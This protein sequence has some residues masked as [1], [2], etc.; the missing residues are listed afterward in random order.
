MASTL[1][2]PA[3]TP[4][5][6]VTGQTCSGLRE[7]AEGCA[8]GTR[9]RPEKGPSALPQLAPRRGC[10]SSDRGLGRLRAVPPTGARDSTQMLNSRTLW[11]Q[12]CSG[13]SS[14]APGHESQGSRA[15]TGVPNSS[16]QFAPSPS[17]TQQS[18]SLQILSV[19]VRVCVRA[20]VCICVR[21]ILET[22]LK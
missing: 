11:G 5:L 3:Q 19:C 13:L 2:E 18:R 9:S 6:T 1:W 10:G 14:Q 20:C 16:A 4:L 7:T 21:E 15:R 8:P 12:G 17:A 22:K